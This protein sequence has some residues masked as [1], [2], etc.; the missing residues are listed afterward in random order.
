[1]TD[2][3]HYNFMLFRQLFVNFCLGGLHNCDRSR[4]SLKPR[5]LY[6]THKD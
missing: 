6:F 2:V 3:N 5:C 4:N 1:M